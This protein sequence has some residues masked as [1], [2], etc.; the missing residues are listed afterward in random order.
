MEL[1]IKKNSSVYGN[2]FSDYLKYTDIII[3]IFNGK[4]NLEKYEKVLSEQQKK[5]IKLLKKE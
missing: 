1:T 5:I 4:I 3:E 2:N